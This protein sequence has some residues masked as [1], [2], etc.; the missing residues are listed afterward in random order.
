[1]TDEA[2]RVKVSVG[3]SHYFWLSAAV[4]VPVEKPDQFN[5]AFIKSQRCNRLHRSSE[6]SG[7]AELAPKSGIDIHGA[8]VRLIPVDG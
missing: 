8:S 7:F 3:S 1:M 5:F 4:D 6:S 2:F